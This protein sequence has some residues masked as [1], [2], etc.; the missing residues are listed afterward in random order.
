[1]RKF[2]FLSF[3]LLSITLFSLTSCGDN[4]D[5]F[6]YP[7]ETLYGTWQIISIKNISSDSYITWPFTTTT[8]TFSSNGTYV[9]N[10]HFGNGSGT[11]TAKGNR[12]TTY[13]DGEV[14]LIYVISLSGT[15]AELKLTDDN[16]SFIMYIKCT[17]K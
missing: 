2:K 6:N 16:S 1:M 11:Y 14:Y 9:G 10:G 3:I 12:I 5:D 4:K 15:T 13:V 17:K 8:A 7:M